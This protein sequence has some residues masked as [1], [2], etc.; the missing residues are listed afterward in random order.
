MEDEIEMIEGSVKDLQQMKVG[1]Y[2]A[3]YINIH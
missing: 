1:Q 3:T 2:Y